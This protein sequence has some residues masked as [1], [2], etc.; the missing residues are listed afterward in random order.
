MAQRI[1]W[2]RAVRNNIWATQGLGLTRRRVPTPHWCCLR[3]AA[4]SSSSSSILPSR[5]VIPHIQIISGCPKCKAALEFPV[6]TPHPRPGALLRIRCFSCENIITHA[7]YATQIPPSSAG[8]SSS[9]AGA[10]QSNAG[11]TPPPRKGRKF[12]TQERPLE[13]GYYDILG[14]TPQVFERLSSQSVS[15]RFTLRRRL[16]PMK[17]RRRIVRVVYDHLNPLC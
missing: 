15:S 4:M 5:A 6:P 8:A 2:G 11:Q 13:T 17:L 7:F 9:T 10:G 14:I 12:G 3:A 1:I 16:Q